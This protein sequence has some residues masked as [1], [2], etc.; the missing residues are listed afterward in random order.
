M[1]KQMISANGMFVT[2]RFIDYA[3]P[4]VGPLPEF[5]SLDVKKKY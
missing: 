2:K 1:P 3:T 4:L 5:A